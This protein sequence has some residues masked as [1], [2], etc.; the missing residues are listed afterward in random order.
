MDGEQNGTQ[1]QQDTQQQ[2]QQAA[3]QQTDQQETQGKH[4]EETG[5]DAGAG[6]GAGAEAYEKQLA[7]RD[8]R[9]AE[10]EA[11][12]ADAAK[13]AEAAEGLR[14]EIAAMK[15][16]GESDR[17]DF[18]LQL[19]GCRNVKAARAVLAGHGGDVDALKAAEPWMFADAPQK[20]IGK[21]GLPNAGTAIDESKQMKRW[22]KIA[23]LSDDE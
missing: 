9:I 21:T 19:A 13:N 18:K 20:Q 23:G 7:E 6:S 3:Q 1:A 10:L 15:E 8:S 14:A 11:Q 4:A 12:V 5:A 16:Q 2:E 22:E 17:I